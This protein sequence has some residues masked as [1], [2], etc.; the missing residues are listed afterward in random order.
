MKALLASRLFDGTAWHADRVVLIDGG[1]IAGIAAPD[2]MPP[3]MAVQRL[4]PDTI[5]APG[6]V[7]LQVNGGGGVL[8]NDE[9]TS[10]GLRR[11]AAAHARVGT[12]SIL[13]TLISGTRPHI[14]RALQAVRDAI[15]LGVPGVAGLHVEGPFIALARRGIHPIEAITAITDDDVAA[16]ASPLP[17]PLLLTVAPEC[18][19]TPRIAALARAGVRVFAGHT[20][21]TLEQARAGLNAGI[22]GFTHLFNAMSQLGSRAPGAVGA[23]LA[24]RTAACGIIVDGYHVH[25]ASVAVAHAAIGPGRMF[26]VSDAMSTTASDTTS[27]V[28]NGRPIQLNGGR[29]TDAA[30]TLAGA[31]LT[32]AEAV[33]NAVGMAGISLGD[34]LRMATATPAGVMGLA[35]RG[36]VIAGALADLIVLG[37]ELGVRA[38]WQGGE[39]L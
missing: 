34:A 6:F 3:G 20:D 30:G 23:A 36:H 11:I 37:P 9:T 12:T 24:D 22:V 16:L 25:P 38:V 4:A 14:A 18:V 28:L 19:D 7:D 17:V 26:L 2:A 29:L 1:R 27:F 10:D 35:D 31:H 15:G 39:Q 8:F 5:L 21:A 13:P 32:M 33:R